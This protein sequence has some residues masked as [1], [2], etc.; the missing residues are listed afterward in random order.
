MTGRDVPALT[1]AAHLVPLETR[2]SV[3]AL[4][5]ESVRIRVVA[6]ATARRL[7]FV[8][9]PHVDAR[10]MRSHRE[11]EDFLSALAAEAG[12]KDVLLVGGDAADALGPYEDALAVIR[13]GLLTKH[14]I[15]HVS[16]AGYPE[17]HPRISTERLWAALSD[18]LQALEEAGL[19]RSIVTQFGFAVDPVLTW[20]AD[21]R[22]RGI[23]VPVRI[24]VPGPAGARRLLRLA[25]RLGVT[26]SVGL[27]CRYSGSVVNL[28]GTAGP[29]R[30]LAG[31]AER[32]D[33]AAHGTVRLHFYT[34]GGMTATAQW[35]RQ[36][37]RGT[38]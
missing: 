27:M 17:G 38:G 9:V 26:S 32:Y 15:E 28:L 22:R 12:A 18:K 31:L 33:E 10:R 1:E 7:G 11:L 30:F 16:V 29:D 19:D 14:G 5:S 8:P 4:A 36:S 25:R 13:T 20:L 6:A 37:R 35:V 21:L 24:G 3:T 23:D 34:F 2:I